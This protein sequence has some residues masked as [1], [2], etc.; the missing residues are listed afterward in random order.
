MDW[1]T[2]Q[3]SFAWCEEAITRFDETKEAAVR[4]AILIALAPCKVDNEAILAFIEYFPEDATLVGTLAGGK[5][6]RC[7]ENWNWASE[8]TRR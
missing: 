6:C 1:K 5:L 8:A 3:L 2:I 4:L 7:E